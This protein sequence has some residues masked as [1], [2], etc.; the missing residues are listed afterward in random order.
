MVILQQNC[1]FFS[2]AVSLPR[3]IQTVI[4]QHLAYASLIYSEK[5]YCDRAA[6]DDPLLGSMLMSLGQCA[7]F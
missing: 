4:S 7:P 1:F 3:G 6:E 2:L 5:M